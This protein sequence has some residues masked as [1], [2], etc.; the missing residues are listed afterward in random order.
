M[1][2]TWEIEIFFA[3][4]FSFLKFFQDGFEVGNLNRL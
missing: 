3:L 1:L 4:F 2:S